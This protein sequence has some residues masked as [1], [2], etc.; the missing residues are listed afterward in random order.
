VPSDLLALWRCADAFE[1]LGD[2]HAGLAA[3]TDRQIH[4]AEAQAWYALSLERWREWNRWGASSTFNEVREARVL[5]AR[6]ASDHAVAALRA[7]EQ[8][9]R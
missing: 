4:W 8:Q 7:S 5:E 3:A 2:F 9:N 6:L 1:R